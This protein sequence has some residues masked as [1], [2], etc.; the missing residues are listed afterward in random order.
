MM[1][2]DLATKVQLKCSTLVRGTILIYL[3]TSL[4]RIGLFHF[5]AGGRKKQL[6]LDVVFLFISVV[7][8]VMDACLLLCLFYF[9]ST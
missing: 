3:L 8:F 9:S 2:S 5:Q 4:L 1:K 7:Y 6:N